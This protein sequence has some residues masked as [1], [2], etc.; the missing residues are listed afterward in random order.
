MTGYFFS[1]TTA[2]DAT[3]PGRTLSGGLALGTGWAQPL[4][5]DA[6]KPIAPYRSQA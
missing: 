4:T 6:R 3:A 5:G 1:R 2:H